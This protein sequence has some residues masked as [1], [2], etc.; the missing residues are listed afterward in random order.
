MNA[1]FEFIPSGTVASPNGFTAGATSAGIKKEK[2]LDLAIL[3]SEV[4]CAAA[5]LFTRNRIKAAPV[6]LCQQRLSGR[7]A[8]GVVVNSGCANACTGEQGLADAE[9]MAALAATVVGT[10]AGQVLVASTGVIGQMMPMER[11]RAGMKQITLSRDGGHELARAIMTT[12]TVPKEV[13]VRVNEGGYIIGGAAKGAGMLHPDLATFLCFLT[14]DAR[15]DA[16]FLQSA[17]QQAADVSFNMVSIDGD[18]STNDT[19]LLLANGLAGNEVISAGTGQAQVFQQALEGL[20]IHLARAVARDGEGAT[21]M[22]EVAVQGAPDRAAARQVARTV[23]SSPLVK[24]AIY[25]ND[26]NWGRLLAA[27]GRSGVEIVESK[28]DLY[29]SDICLLKAGRPQPFDRAEA[30]KHIDRPEV[31]FILNLN[32]GDGSAVAWGCDLTE[33]YAEINSHYTT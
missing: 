33:D 17:L 28:I 10:A 29:L 19:L 30:V 4:P 16:G 3:A 8:T 7:K 15:V 32:L 2:I 25:G 24:A 22:F 5:G 31:T 23:V 18:T 21:K 13:A 12:D 1:G 9:E 20:C 14:T 26:P 11:L 6:V 27:A